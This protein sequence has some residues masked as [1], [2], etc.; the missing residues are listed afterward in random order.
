MM[1]KAILLWLPHSCFEQ[2][3]KACLSEDQKGTGCQTLSPALSDGR[4]GKGVC[5]TDLGS[6]A[7]AFIPGVER[8]DQGQVRP[9]RLGQHPAIRQSGAHTENLP[10]AEIA[11]GLHP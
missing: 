5:T 2:Q 3:R 10:A 9:T 11:A 1:A 6:A 4:A 8:T 7:E